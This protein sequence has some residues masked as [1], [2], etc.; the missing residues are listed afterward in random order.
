MSDQRS[1]RRFIEP[2]SESSSSNS[3]P[4]LVEE[5]QASIDPAVAAEQV[6]NSKTTSH[7]SKEGTEGARL[8]PSDAFSVASGGLDGFDM[9]QLEEELNVAIAAELGEEAEATPERTI[10][11]QISSESESTEPIDPTRDRENNRGGGSGR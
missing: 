1:T 8:Q 5:T 9:N 6:V 11:E 7:A 10:E 2:P 3:D 4:E